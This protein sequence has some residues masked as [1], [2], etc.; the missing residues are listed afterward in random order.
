M[1]FEPI[2]N[3]G[4]HADIENSDTGEITSENIVNHDFARNL[5]T[6]AAADGTT[7]TF[8]LVYD[9]SKSPTRGWNVDNL[10]L[11][12]TN[13][14]DMNSLQV[15]DAEGVTL[16]PEDIFQS[17][18]YSTFIG[19]VLTCIE[20]GVD[21]ERPLY[22]EFLFNRLIPVG[23]EKDRQDVLGDLESAQKLLTGAAYEYLVEKVNTWYERK[24]AQKMALVEKEEAIPER[25]SRAFGR[26]R[27]SRYQK[28]DNSQV[29]L[30]TL[31]AVCIAYLVLT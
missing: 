5:Y 16:T 21:L 25:P 3:E 26:S 12:I 22:Q 9:N 28:E 2:L 23:E 31:S 1:P 27:K 30:L 11:S 15:F 6:T 24:E 4:G 20:N 7:R 13:I 17:D 14:Y 10:P 8:S 18:T 29:I 19:L